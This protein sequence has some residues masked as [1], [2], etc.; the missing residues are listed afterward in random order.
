MLSRAINYTALFALLFGSTLARGTDAIENA[1]SEQS[2]SATQINAFTQALAHTILGR[3]GDSATTGSIFGD[4]QSQ[5]HL[6]EGAGAAYEMLKDPNNWPVLLGAMSASDREKLAQA[7]EQGDGRTI[8]QLRGAQLVNLP[9]GS[10]AALGTIK[11]IDKGVLAAED[12][13]KAGSKLP[14]SGVDIAHTIGADYNPRTGKVTGGHSLLNKDVRV[15]EVVSP[16]DLH[17]VYVAKVQM[18]APDGTWINKVSNAGENT[19]FPK[20]WDATKIQTEI[21][22]AWND[23]NKTVVRNK[24]SGT[25]SSGV[26]IEGFIEPKTTAYPVYSRGK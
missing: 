18:Q 7:Y 2:S 11:K 16:P 17:G 25:S 5:A 6:R 24:W 9:M 1:A 10:G 4:A 15:T 20:D 8:G 14:S 12:I 3:A 13:A 19:M 23:T 21:D 26:K 22:S